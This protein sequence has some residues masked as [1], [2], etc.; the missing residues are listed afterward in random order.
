MNPRVKAVIDNHKTDL[1]LIFRHYPLA[2][3]KLAR[4]AA[5]SAEAAGNS[6]KFWQ[7]H[8]TLYKLNGGIDANSVTSAQKQLQLKQM[9]KNSPEYK[10][11]SN[12]VDEDRALGDQIGLEHTPTFV[13][14]YPDGRAVTIDR[15]S[16]IDR[17]ITH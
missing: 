11:F 9:P 3:H 13:L 8:D 7:F 6:G 5:I 10:Q 12:Y 15:L 14:C 4:E 2:Q 1:R 17:F 16:E